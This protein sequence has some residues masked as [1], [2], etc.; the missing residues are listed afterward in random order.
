MLG[1]A[2][3]FFGRVRAWGVTVLDLPTAYWHELVAELERGAAEVPPCVRLT[4]IGGERALPE[5]VAAWRRLAGGAA[6]LVDT[7]GPTETT[8]AATLAELAG[9]AVSIGRPVPN[10]RAC[11]LDADL[12]PLPV[13][14]RGEL[15]VGGAGVARGYLGRP[16][17]TAERFVP[18]PFPGEPGARIYRTGDVVRWRR[19]GELEYVGRADDQ[20]KV[21]G[22]RVEPGE[23]ASV[24]LR[25]PGVREAVVVA[26]EDEPGRARLVAYV[27]PEGGVGTAEL[28]AHLKAE[29]PE[30]MVPTAWV[31][32]DALPQLPNGK[33]DRRALPAPE[34]RA[35]AEYVAPR[36]ENQERLAEI[37]AGLLRVDRVGAHDGFFAL[38]GHSLLATRVVS[39][40]R[41]Q[42][43]VEVPL[44]AV[45]EGPTVA[46]LARLLPA[47][48]ASVPAAEAIHAAASSVEEELLGRLDELSD[49][50]ME[51][52]L[53]ELSPE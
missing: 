40:I 13:G 39:R 42:W 16:E 33:T 21:R 18:D 47:G 24:L 27:V 14:V 37:W 3:T 28:R 8:V 49:A 35:E 31:A 4:I 5:R 53:A 45:F 36:G 7:Y 26:R 12:R 10:A 44:R 17:L 52:L 25:H 22:Y 1:S 41:E 30:H 23:V 29:L 15:Y 50:E 20:V 6:R 46:E 38:G 2:A 51:R 11:V 19:D 9:G 48:A 34:A 32:L 43:G